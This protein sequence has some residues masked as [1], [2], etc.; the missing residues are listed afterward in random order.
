M[1][2]QKKI[3]SVKIQVN[4][5]VTMSDAVILES[6]ETEM[7]RVRVEL[8]KTKRE[9]EEKKLEL[10][11][12][13]AREYS[14]Q[15]IDISNRQIAGFARGS[16]LKDK[17][18]QEKAYDNVMVTGKFIN[19]RAPGQ[20]VKLTYLKYAD[21]PVKWYQMEDNKI[22]TIPRGFADQIRDYYHTPHFIQKD[23]IMDPN[24][25]ASAIHEVDT[26]NKKYDFVNTNW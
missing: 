15:E 14:K 8:E 17:I 25:P 7:D 22:Y 24:K 21:D 1:A 12:M 11:N 2:R 9:L 10:Q 6:L 4:N 13:P 26:T 3:K 19:R 18:E 5:E 23:G 16:A 20:G